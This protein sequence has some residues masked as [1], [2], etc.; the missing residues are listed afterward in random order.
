MEE[1]IKSVQG[2]LDV[3]GAVHMIVGCTLG[4]VLLYLLVRRRQVE[5]SES[6]WDRWKDGGRAA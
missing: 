1:I 2:M 6:E 3:I 5:Q 4:A